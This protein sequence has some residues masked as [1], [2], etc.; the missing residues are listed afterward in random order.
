MEYI[1][2]L[3]DKILKQKEKNLNADMLDLEKEID[4][5]VYKLNNLTYEEACIIEGSKEWMSKE[6]Y[7]QFSI[8]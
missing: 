7:E 2:E 6:V 4:L 1:S 3:I 5:R 8:E